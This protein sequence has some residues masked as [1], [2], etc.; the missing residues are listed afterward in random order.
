MSNKVNGKVWQ[1]SCYPGGHDCFEIQDH[2]LDNTKLGNG[3]LWSLYK[4]YV[5]LYFV[6]Y[7]IQQW[8]LII[9]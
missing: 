1:W 6:K 7:N 5:I 4:N 2:K 9:L 3:R 8:R